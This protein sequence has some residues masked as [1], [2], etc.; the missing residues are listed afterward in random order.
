MGRPLK[1]PPHGGLQAREV[2]KGPRGPLGVKAHLVAPGEQAPK[3]PL[4]LAVRAEA[5]GLVPLGGLQAAGGAGAQGPAQGLLRGAEEGEGPELGPGQGP[6]EAGEEGG[7]VPELLSP[8]GQP[9]QVGHEARPPPQGPLPPGLPRLLQGLLRLLRVGEEEVEL[10]PRPQDAVQGGEAQTPEDSQGH[11]LRGQAHLEAPGPKPLGDAPHPRLRPGDAVDV[12]LDAPHVPH[13]QEELLPIPAQVPRLG[14]PP[15]EEPEG[16]GDGRGEAQVVVEA[17]V[18]LRLGVRGHQGKG[19]QK[20]QGQVG[21]EGLPGELEGL[22]LP[23]AVLEAFQKPLVDLPGDVGVGFRV[24]GPRGQAH[25]ASLREGVDGAVPPFPTLLPLH[26]EVAERRLQGHVRGASPIPSPFPLPGGVGVRQGHAPLLGGLG[27]V[28]GAVP[29][30]LV[31]AARRSGEPFR[32]HPRLLE[33]PGVL[34]DEKGGVG[35][36]G[37]VRNPWVLLVPMGAGVELAHVVQKPRQG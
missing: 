20:G 9:G 23:E 22:H 21:E 36:V 27:L 24:K 14:V 2:Q 8:E 4:P 7:E 31:V 19:L 13:R 37:A 5:S 11:G 3:L 10:A 15:V 33:E 18:G 17:H 1:L 35:G 6:V 25:P 30:A 29:P 34:P 28:L 12:P 32:V 26:P 16:V